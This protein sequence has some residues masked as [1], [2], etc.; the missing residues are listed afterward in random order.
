MATLTELIAEDTVWHFGGTSSL[1]GDYEGRDAV[2]GL[3]AELAQRSEGTLKLEIH[4]FLANDDHTVALV[5]ITAGGSHGRTL[6]VNTAD[7]LHIVGGQVAEFW[8][9]PSDQRAADA[10]WG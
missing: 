10:Y 4:D 2:F 5:H 3:F 1:A 6:D 9:F 7:T 8:S